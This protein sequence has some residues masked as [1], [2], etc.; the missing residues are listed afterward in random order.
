M[1]PLT[2][3]ICIEA[4][5][6]IVRYGKTPALMIPEFSCRGR[7]IALIGH[8]GS[9]KSTFIKTAL[10]LITPHSGTLTLSRGVNRLSPERHM[11]Y[12]PENGAVFADVTVED[13][14]RLWCRIKRNDAEYYRRSGSG[15]VE[16]LQIPA[17][18]RK[19]G[20]ELSKG[21]RRRVQIA[22]G[23]LIG[24]QLLCLDEPLE[25]LDIQQAAVLTSVMRECAAETSLI[26]S[27]HRIDVVERLADQI[28]ML[29]D[30]RI[31][32]HGDLQEV[33][34]QL[35]SQTMI[36]TPKSRAGVDLNDLTSIL[37][38]R[39][40]RS[41]VYRTGAQF[42]LTGSGLTAEA[43]KILF[44]SLNQ[45]EPDLKLIPPTLNDAVHAY[46]KQRQ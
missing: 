23:F 38:Q 35:G 9:G 7:V 41:L 16:Q 40:H 12:S 10:Q 8:N 33:S 31:L 39:F 13:Y 26:I 30:G 11:A 2:D 25:G 1:T 28:I 20:R 37:Q 43:V 21:Q 15:L 34:A 27:S 17:L 29:D 24:P 14:L 18:F 3:E 19:L 45:P 6:L 42:V 32:A 4:K 44:S 5:E 22:V 36:L 46:L